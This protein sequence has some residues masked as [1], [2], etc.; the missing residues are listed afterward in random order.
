[1]RYQITTLQFAILCGLQCRTYTDILK[2]N[3]LQYLH[4]R[5]IWVKKSL[6]EV[7]FTFSLVSSEVQ[8]AL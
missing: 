5:A 1:M 3:V 7:D 8:V 2:S 6:V 4:L